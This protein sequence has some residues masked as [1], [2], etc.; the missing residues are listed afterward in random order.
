MAALDTRARIAR[1]LQRT[2]F[3]VRAADVDFAMAAGFDGTLDAILDDRRDPGA[4]ATPAPDIGPLPPRNV[5]D[6]CALQQFREAKRQQ[7]ERL[8]LW[9]LDRMTA[10]QRPWREKRT[11]L[12]HDHW[13]TSIQKVESGRAMLVQNETLR[14]LGDGDFRK[15]ARH[16]VTDPALMR[17]LDASSNVAKGPNE[18]LARELMELFVLG[19]NNYKVR[20][21]RQAAAALTGWTIDM[22]GKDGWRPAFRPRLHAQGPQTVLGRTT[23][24]TAQT[25]VDHLVDEPASAR[26][27]ASRF[28]ARLVSSENPPSKQSMERMV[29]AYG[30]KHDISRMLRALFTDPAF[31]DPD[32][33]LVKQPVEY[34]VGSLRAFGVRPA[35][36][37]PQ[38][39]RQLLGILGGLGQVPFA[40][41]NVGGWPHGVAW[42]TTSAAAVR[43][44]F[45]QRLA[46]WA[47]LSAIEQE[48]ATERPA[49]LARLL[50]VDAWS[51]QTT[52]VLAAAA[53]DP[54]RVTAIAL[55]APEYLVQP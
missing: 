8:T 23:D 19:V 13:A 24:F 38:S 28:W 32:N 21:V 4:A 2:G 35:K 29:R 12:W 33:V 55:T 3:G 20:D 42:L 43:I 40:P 37:P 15:L 51:K 25:L 46:G 5:K 30:K 26:H 49:V 44:Q 6:A 34:L 36:L 54:R 53:E 39:R 31:A 7:R 1:L 27:V 48:Y 17:W 10:A 47:D 14:S 16:M 50:G 9:W 52:A 18:N 45:A 11:F 41:P 22:S